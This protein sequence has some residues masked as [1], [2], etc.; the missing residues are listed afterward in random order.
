MPAG[1]RSRIQ[2]SVLPITRSMIPLKGYR[3]SG[4]TCSQRITTF[5][6][7]VR[8]AKVYARAWRL[9]RS[10][11]FA[12]LKF[13]RANR[14]GNDLLIRQQFIRRDAKGKNIHPPRQ[15]ASRFNCSGAM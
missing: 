14:R 13:H 12:P 1:F 9:A 8:Q 11:A 6:S 3:R 7:A 2:Y 15:C 5:S 10:T 4:S